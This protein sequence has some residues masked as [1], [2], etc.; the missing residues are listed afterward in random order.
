M[1]V[2]ATLNAQ[3]RSDIGKGKNRKL[4]AT[5]RIPAVVYGHHEQTRKL[6]VDA[7]DFDRL[8]ATVRVENTIINLSVEGERGPVKALVREVQ[9]HPV[10][11]SVLHIDFYQIHADEAVTVEVPIRLLGSAVGVRAG[12]I[13][14]HALIALEISCLPDNIPE[15]FEVD[16]SNLEIGDS[17]HV[18]D[19]ALPPGVEAQVDA[20]RSVCSVIP[21]AVVPVEEVAAEAAAAEEA[22]EPE[23]IGR[24][25]EGEEEEEG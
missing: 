22:A 19:I 8:L 5:G 24:G 10:R 16:V 23:V 7:H 17:V 9:T 2:K 11:E 15:V 6:T 3:P 25:K 4:R 21:P 12:G 1:A 14:Q 20:E 13:M 18:G